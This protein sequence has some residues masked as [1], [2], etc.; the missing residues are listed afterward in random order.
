MHNIVES[1]ET[2]IADGR[3]RIDLSGHGPLVIGVDEDG[4][5]NISRMYPDVE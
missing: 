5:V 3:S 4:Y 2:K 1:L